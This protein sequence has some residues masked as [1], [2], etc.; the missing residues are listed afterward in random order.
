[1]ESPDLL[2]RN[3]SITVSSDFRKRLLAAVRARRRRRAASRIAV[4]VMA[5]ACAIGLT[6]AALPHASDPVRYEIPVAKAK[7]RPVVV[8][9]PIPVPVPKIA[10]ARP[11]RHP[12]THA[13]H[14]VEVA[15]KPPESGGL[16]AIRALTASPG[17]SATAEL[18]TIYRRQTEPEIRHAVITALFTRRDAHALE[19][20]A[21]TE[22]D[23]ALRA[24]LKTKA[25]QV[26][27][28]EPDYLPARNDPNN[29]NP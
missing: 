1:M 12:A 14:A 26:P 20:L 22:T 23:P 16:E 7:P 2:P 27:K 15:A 6:W 9:I 28:N 3:H 10:K 29:P 4:V 24:E 13:P 19:S 11:H 5:G 8:P 21:R 17:P 18:I 25:V